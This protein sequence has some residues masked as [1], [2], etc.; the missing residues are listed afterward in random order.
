MSFVKRSTTV[1][2]AF[3]RCLEIMEENWHLSGCEGRRIN[4]NKKVGKQQKE[5]LLAG[6]G[7]GQRIWKGKAKEVDCRTEDKLSVLYL[8]QWES[9]EEDTT[10]TLS[11]AVS[12][13]NLLFTFQFLINYSLEKSKM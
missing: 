10:Y 9:A 2:R 4:E 3:I 1:T 6:E 8:S 12:E 7:E 5:V 13:M 11:G